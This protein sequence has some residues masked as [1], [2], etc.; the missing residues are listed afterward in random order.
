MLA[1][2]SIRTNGDGQGAHPAVE[3]R[4][5]EIILAGNPHK[6][7]QRIATRVSG[8]VNSKCRRCDRFF[9]L[10]AAGQSKSVRPTSGPMID[11]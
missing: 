10:A 8:T 4:R 6:R 5:I 3:V 1:T 2:G 9:Q 7:E 11:A